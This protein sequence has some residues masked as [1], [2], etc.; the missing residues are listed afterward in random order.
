MSK[1]G[2]LGALLFVS[3]AA[4]ALPPPDT[5]VVSARFSPST[6]A[7]GQSTTFTWSATNGAY[8]DVDGLPGGWRSGSSGS[9][10]FAATQTLT[11]YVSCENGM[12]F[13]S[14]SAT[15][16]VSNAAPTVTTSFS[17]STVYVGGSGS[18]FSWNSTMAS[19][20]SSPQ[21]GGVAGTSGSI[22][23]PAAGAASQQT[24]TVNCVGAN[25]SGSSSSTL[26]TAVAPPAPPYVSAWASPSYLYGPGFTSIT[27]TA[28]NATSCSG[29]GTYYVNFSTSF[30]V[31][32]W[33]PGGSATSWAFVSVAPPMYKLGGAAPTPSVAPASVAASKDGKPAIKRVPPALA[34]LGMDLTKL[35]YE[36]VEADMDHDGSVD[37]IVLDKTKSQAHIVLNKAGRHVTV[38]TVNNI[39]SLAQIKG[40][41]VPVSGAAAEIRVT[42]EQQQ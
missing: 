24:V 33:G 40:V 17:P 16:T 21:L 25:G 7:P 11:A 6:V 35:R 9:Y 10:T 39:G 5:V 36:Y 26:T 22:A 38:K 2:I 12:G 15:L 13:G 8:C 27:Y 34:H 41:F 29:W 32:C 20:C 37:L 14:R 18:T 28:F 30:P 1:I 23:V 19:S 4:S 42:V 31:T 3:T